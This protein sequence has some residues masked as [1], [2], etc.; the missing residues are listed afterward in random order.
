[1][2]ASVGSLIEESK[3]SERR[4][5][6]PMMSR[7]CEV[8]PT[9]ETGCLAVWEKCDVVHGRRKNQVLYRAV[10]SF[11]FPPNQCTGFYTERSWHPVIGCK[12]WRWHGLRSEPGEIKPS[13]CVSYRD[14]RINVISLLLPFIGA[15]RNRPTARVCRIQPK[16]PEGLLRGPG[17]E[18]PW[19]APCTCR[20]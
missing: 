18:P 5:R 10:L 8:E 3:G 20:H 6:E 1:V 9:S 2:A 12:P 17:S 14:T 13:T 7:S 11:L 4:C 16:I 15:D 19:H